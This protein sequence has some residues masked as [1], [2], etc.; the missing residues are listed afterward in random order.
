MTVRVLVFTPTWGSALRPETEAALAGQQ[1]DG[2]LV[3]E[4]GRENPYPPPD[5][6]NVLAQ[7]R[8]GWALAL[9]GG[10]DALWTVEH[11][12]APPPN[13]LELLWGADAPVAYGVYL[14]RHGS[15]VVNALQASTGRNIGMSLSLHPAELAQARRRGVVEV[16]GVGFGCTLIRRAV[17]EQI[18]LRPDLATVGDEQTPDMP[19]AT[20]CVR[21]GVR[22]VAHFGVLCGH[23][24]RGKV[25][26]VAEGGAGRTQVLAL[27]TVVV[28][29]PQRLEA[30]QQYALDATLADELARAGYV[31]LLDAPAEA[32]D[33]TDPGAMGRETA[34]SGAQRRK[35][36]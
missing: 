8:V 20:D 19:F 33:A 1:W 17:L 5:L 36:R 28:E 7:Y 6:R 12:M 32:E 18:A 21:A 31:R 23:V 22:Q 24:E 16:S 2:A 3:W 11:D 9:A 25:L 15:N 13:A 10:Y 35:R 29:G 4:V 27:Q 34:V 26:Q 14:L 30:G